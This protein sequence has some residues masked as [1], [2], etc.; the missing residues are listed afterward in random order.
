LGNHLL[1]IHDDC[2]FMYISKVVPLHQK[3][4]I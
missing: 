4:W 1:L 2:D 3:Q